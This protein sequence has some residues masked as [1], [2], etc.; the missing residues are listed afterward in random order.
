MH[1]QELYMRRALELASLGRGSVSPNPMVGCVIVKDEHII[2]E[3]FHQQYG[4]PHAEVNAI[5]SVID[6]NDLVG[7]DMY[8]TLEPCSHHGKTPP[9]ADLIIQYPFRKI[10]IANTD[11]NP[12]VAGKG[13][14]K[15]KQHGID[16]AIGLLEVEAR[17]L[18]KRFFT[19]IEKNR[20]YII[21]KW[22]ETA[23]GFVAR[24]DYTS[25]WI[26]NDIS[27]QMVHQWRA[28]EDAIIVATNTAL[29]DN[30]SLTLRHWSGTQP[31]RVAIDRSLKL[32]THL[33]LLDGA[34]PT[35]IYNLIKN[36]SSTN[37]EYVKLSGLE[38]ILLE[39]LRDLKNRK[40]Q[41]VI[42]E[43]GSQLLQSFIAQ[44]LWDEARIFKSVKTFQSGIKAP[45]I[46]GQQVHIT[47]IK[48]DVL[49]V[50]QNPIAI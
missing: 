19:A 5:A 48:N 41:S 44:N 37:L 43:G 38:N 6:K 32:P 23:D 13:I 3:G 10:F 11:T 39:V 9:C 7:A 46:K 25:Q 50:L 4:G 45:E 12:L 14:E 27:R 30:P 40:I 1:S 21:L 34:I 31:L 16:V 35:V 49:T 36:E 17:I 20:P 24:N 47:Y 26:S 22:A 8:V 28:E 42:V 29:Y 33:H 2:G 15:I 18:N